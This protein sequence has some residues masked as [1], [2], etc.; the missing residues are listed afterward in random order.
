MKL[1]LPSTNLEYE[2]NLLPDGNK[3]TR[4]IVS[5]GSE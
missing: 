1:I 2:S 5:Q 4:V 3:L